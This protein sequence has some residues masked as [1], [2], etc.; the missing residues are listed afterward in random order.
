MCNKILKLNNLPDSS[1]ENFLELMQ[2]INST[3]LDSLGI[4]RKDSTI[5]L[6]EDGEAI[7]QDDTR[8]F[9]VRNGKLLEYSVC[10]KCP[11]SG[12]SDQLNLEDVKGEKLCDDCV[13]SLIM[14]MAPL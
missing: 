8:L 14:E 6:N 5:Y 4:V 13:D 10:S 7:L 3:D 12:F 11:S 9:K 2:A 1:M